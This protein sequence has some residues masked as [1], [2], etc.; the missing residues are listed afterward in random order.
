MIQISLSI[1]YQLKNFCISF[2][3]LRNLQKIGLLE[4]ITIFIDI[5]GYSALNREV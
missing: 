2:I 3:K 1:L 5:L 4:K